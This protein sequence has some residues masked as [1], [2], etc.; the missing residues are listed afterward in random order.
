MQI[1]LQRYWTLLATYLRPQRLRFAALAALL[2]G[3]IGLELLNP[4]ILRGFIDTALAGGSEASLL[5]TALLFAGVALAQQIVAVLARYVSEN[6]GWTATNALRGDLVEHCLRLD[7][8]FHKARTPGE[9][10]ERV[11]GDVTALASFFSQLI[12][13]VLGSLLLMV[14]VLVLLFREDWRAGLAIGLFALAALAVM[15]RLRTAAVPLWNAERE[16]NAQFFGFLG[17]QIGGT[18]DLRANGATGYVMRRFYALLRGW[19]PVARRAHLASYSMWMTTI[20]LFALGSA[21]SLGLGAYLWSQGAISIGTVYL[22]FTYTELLRRPMEQIRTQLQDLQKADASITRIQR[23]LDIRPRIA[24]GPGATLPAGALAVEFDRVSFGYEHEA[25]GL[26]LEAS[27]DGAS[28]DAWTQDPN[29]D[30]HS[31]YADP[32]APS[33]D[34]Q[35]PSLQ[36]LAPDLVLH[37][38]SFQLRPGEVLGLLGRTGS[39]K[40][41]TARLLLRLYDPLAGAVR[42]GGVD[43]RDAHLAD[44]R[45]R[46]GVVTQ[47]VQ[48]FQGSVRDNLTFYDRSIPDGRILAALEELGLRGWAEG[49]PHGLET[50]LAAG[51]GLSAGEAQLLAFTRVL[52]ADPGLV[53]LDEA[54]SRLDPA[55]EQLIERAVGRL[56]RGRTAVIIAHRLSTVQRADTIMLLEGG[57]IAEYGPRAALAADPETRFAA[58]LRTGLEEVLA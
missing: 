20:I 41:T 31:P 38:L 48:L 37:H 22:L 56:L 12:I 1:S 52:L 53:I 23:L 44:L 15:T 3:S 10:I 29:A 58:L 46:V 34:P 43:L 49:L 9:L 39:G 5:Q 40:S 13:S 28:L 32:P 26:R 30:H 54:S 36:P 25:R 4:Q 45:R 7:Q 14:G 6:V 19:L 27:D 57:R 33:P 11:D 51:G 21:I 17:E 18:E 55:T 24:D 2:L 47:E 16:A 8:S 35:A 42:L 50:E